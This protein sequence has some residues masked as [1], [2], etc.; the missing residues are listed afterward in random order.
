MQQI[1]E[2]LELMEIKSYIWN[3]YSDKYLNIH[4]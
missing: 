3:Y 1:T 4:L 2:S